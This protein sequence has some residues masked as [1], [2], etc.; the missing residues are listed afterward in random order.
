MSAVPKRSAQQDAPAKLDVLPPGPTFTN[1]EPEQLPLRLLAVISERVESLHAGQRAMSAEIREIRAGL[2]QQRR[3]SSSRPQALHI[4]VTA[5]LRNGLCPCCQST[6]VLHRVGSTGRF[7]VRP[8]FQSEPDPPD[9]D[10]ARVR[11]VQPA[12]GRA[13]LPF[14]ADTSLRDHSH[15]DLRKIG[16][17]AVTAPCSQ[18]LQG[19]EG[20]NQIR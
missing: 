16:L 9:A 5:A 13:G 6:P 12:V 15:M 8:L 10:L 11:Q 18:G 3:P 1:C 19:R 17:V 14:E 7:G 2:P 4:A 20:K